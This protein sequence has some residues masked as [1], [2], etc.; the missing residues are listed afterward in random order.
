M[1]Y[2][3]DFLNEDV[4]EVKNKIKKLP[5]EDQDSIKKNVSGIPKKK[6][7]DQVKVTAKVD[8][9]VIEITSDELRTV[10]Y[11]LFKK[12]SRGNK[13]DIYNSLRESLNTHEIE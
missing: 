6:A 11:I 8:K 13:R 12:S 5:E 7:K 9:K 4:P 1:S 10:Y 2:F 3:E